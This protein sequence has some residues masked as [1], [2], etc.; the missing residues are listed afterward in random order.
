M[1]DDVLI[2]YEARKMYF[3]RFFVLFNLWFVT[4]VAG[5]LA[6]SVE[7]DLKS[8]SRLLFSDD[9]LTSKQWFISTSSQ[10][11]FNYST[12][13]YQIST[14][15]PHTWWWANCPFTD[16]NIFDS[17]FIV[18]VSAI[19]AVADTHKDGGFGIAFDQTNDSNF[20]WISFNRHG[21]YKMNRWVNGSALSPPIIDWTPCRAYVNGVPNSIRIIHDEDSVELVVNGVSIVKSNE[22][23]IP[24]SRMKI[25]ILVDNFDDTGAIAHFY[26]FRLFQQ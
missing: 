1:A 10:R 16:A 9:F 2:N 11:S 20:G 17:P 22:F 5:V 25:S 26:K 18:D 6:Q 8:D 4:L 21:Y 12:D 13:G 7:S 14:S 23:A 24:K 15:Q 19:V 3:V